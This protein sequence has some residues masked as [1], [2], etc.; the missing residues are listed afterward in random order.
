MT[1]EKKIFWLSNNY[2]LK[3]HKDTVT[4]NS[5]KA[6]YGLKDM[7]L[8]D[9]AMNRPRNLYLYENES[10]TFKLAASLV[11]GLVKNHAFI[12]GN[13][14]T[15]FMAVNTFLKINGYRMESLAKDNL[16]KFVELIEG[17]ISEREFSEWLK[18]VCK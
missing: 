7:N 10:E 14:R 8:F 1:K 9:S 2:V 5:P 6:L 18:E 16:A 11:Y 12:D 17:K 13:K 3:I 4:F 15:A